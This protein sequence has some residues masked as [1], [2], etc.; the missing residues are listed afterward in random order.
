MDALDMDK[1][2]VKTAV[3]PI[4]EDLAHHDP[5]RLVQA[6][7]IDLLGEYKNPEYRSFFIEKSTDSSYSVA[8][9]A[10]RALGA[11][12]P[13]EA[14]K[15]AEDFSKHPAKGELLTAMGDIFIKNGDTTKFDLMIE[16]FDKMPMGQSK[17]ES[18]PRFAL[19][20]LKIQN[21]EQVKRG[22]D[23]IVRFQKAI[24][25]SQRKEISQLINNNILSPIAS[26]K[27][28]MGLKAQAEYIREKIGEE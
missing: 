15:L 23:A 10:L 1:Q 18:L 9:N 22:I 12:D 4:L 21:D 19:S 5:Y 3:Q 20:L 26:R 27:E 25:S 8:G 6:K 14:T 17:V 7:A 2:A 13:D 11:I 16:G 24:P 28:A